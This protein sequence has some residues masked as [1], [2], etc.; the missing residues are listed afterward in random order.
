[1]LTNQNGGGVL[2]PD[3]V[4]TKTGLPVL[5]V[6]KSKHPKL[7]DLPSVG[8]LDG[9]FELYPKGASVFVPAVV[10]QCVVE[11]MAKQ[12]SGAA[13]SSRTGAVMLANQ[14]LQYK[15]G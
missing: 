4:C 7:Q 15:S 5:E 3:N 11:A 1:M 9:T 8:P 13:G 12:L 14:F 2:Q 6:L 10:I